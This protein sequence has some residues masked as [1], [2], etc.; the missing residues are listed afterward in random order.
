MDH[1]NEHLFIDHLLKSALA[2]VLGEHIRVNHS[3]ARQALLNDQAHP[4]SFLFFAFLLSD[5]FLFLLLLFIK[6][7]HCDISLLFLVLLISLY[8]GLK[9][10]NLVLPD[11]I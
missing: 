10:R 9:T 11:A 2:F 8:I 5:P 3:R 6:S 7:S 1:Q 4:E